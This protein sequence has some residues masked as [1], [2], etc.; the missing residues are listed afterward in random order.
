MISV[1]IATK[2]QNCTVQEEGIFNSRQWTLMEGECAE[3]Y[4]FSPSSH[5]SNS[6]FLNFCD[7]QILHF[8]N[9]AILGRHLDDN[10]VGQLTK[11]KWSSTVSCWT[12]RSPQLWRKKSSQRSCPT[13]LCQYQ[14]KK[15]RWLGKGAKKPPRA[16]QVHLQSFL[17]S[18]WIRTNAIFFLQVEESF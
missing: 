2:L 14:P 5:F 4:N 7:F 11:L 6:A 13:F 16:R 10:L 8:S 1:R 17:I 3:L 15:T 12:S 9:F 18:L